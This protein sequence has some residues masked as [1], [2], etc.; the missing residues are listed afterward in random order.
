MVWYWLQWMPH[1]QSQLTWIAHIPDIK[2]QMEIRLS[3]L[4]GHCHEHRFKNSR[5]QKHILQQRKPTRTG[6]VLIKIKMPV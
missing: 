1:A 2:I 3:G 6:P 5:F 4:K